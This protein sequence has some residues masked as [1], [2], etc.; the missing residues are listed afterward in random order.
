M[1]LSEAMNT[2]LYLEMILDQEI[3]IA[4]KNPYY[5]ISVRMITL[6]EWMASA[7]TGDDP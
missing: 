3:V 1:H 5:D 4:S 7:P 6:E 2:L